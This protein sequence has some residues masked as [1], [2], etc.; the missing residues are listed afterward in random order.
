MDERDGTQQDAASTSEPQ[1]EAFMSIIEDIQSSEPQSGSAISETQEPAIHVPF[2]PDPNN[3]IEPLQLQQQYSSFCPYPTPDASRASSPQLQKEEDFCNSPPPPLR[4][5][6][7]KPSE[8]PD[9]P[10]PPPLGIQQKPSPLTS[11]HRDRYSPYDL[12]PYVLQDPIQ[13]WAIRLTPKR[14]QYEVESSSPES[15]ALDDDDAY[16]DQA[17]TPTRGTEGR[18]TKNLHTLEDFG[19]RVRVSGLRGKEPW[20]G[21]EEEVGK[22]KGKMADGDELNQVKSERASGR[23]N[24]N[25]LGSKRAT[26]SSGGT[27]QPR[28]RDMSESRR[29]VMATTTIPEGKPLSVHSSGQGRPSS[30]V[31]SRSASGS[32][33][34]IVIEGERLRPDQIPFSYTQL[35]TRLRTGISSLVFLA[36][37]PDKPGP[38]KRALVTR[39]SVACS[40]EQNCRNKVRS[41]NGMAAVLEPNRK[42]QVTGGNYGIEK[43]GAAESGKDKQQD[44]CR[45]ASVAASPHEALVLKAGD[46]QAPETTAVT[47]SG[48]ALQCHVDVI[49]RECSRERMH[50]KA[51][52]SIDNAALHTPRVADAACQTDLVPWPCATANCNR[53]SEKSLVRLCNV[54]RAKVWNNGNLAHSGTRLVADGSSFCWECRLKKSR[55]QR[56]TQHRERAVKSK[57]TSCGEENEEKT[58]PKKRKLVNAAAI[59]GEDEV[60]SPAKRCCTGGF[61]PD[62]RGPVDENA[63]AIEQDDFAMVAQDPDLIHNTAKVNPGCIFSGVFAEGLEAV[64][65]QPASPRTELL[66]TKPICSLN[67]SFKPPEAAAIT[68]DCQTRVVSASGTY[69]AQRRVPLA[70]ITTRV[71]SHSSPP[72]SSSVKYG[73][74]TPSPLQSVQAAEETPPTSPMSPTPTRGYD[75]VS[76]SLCSLCRQLVAYDDHGLCIPCANPLISGQKRYTAKKAR[77]K[78]LRWIHRHKVESVQ[79]NVYGY[80]YASSKDAQV[81]PKDKPKPLKGI[82]KRK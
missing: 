63:T 39:N 2:S 17:I 4:K 79:E 73:S 20:S 9:K 35:D 21:L 34:E 1:C 18:C 69:T 43:S 13:V 41:E 72:R 61:G 68:S 64:S 3:D 31:P 82:L 78:S 52:T 51:R 6:R 81:L 65:L 57:E 23:G 42:T 27:T 7:Q 60:T 53:P 40:Q 58:R 46:V 37:A 36:P 11:I 54:E 32:S 62:S 66:L 67:A 19:R 28:S 30:T 55:R 29:K 71:V 56:K 59:L 77:R 50:A 49:R 75:M 48:S 76:S 45:A 25:L 33:V 10:C 22:T 16:N 15:L 8:L 80:A 12:L 70:D 5:D 74:Y 26:K 14:S 24:A 47:Q 44:E 38:I